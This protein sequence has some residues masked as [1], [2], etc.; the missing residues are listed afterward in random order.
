MGS[1]CKRYKVKCLD[2]STVWV[3]ARWRLKPMLITG[4]PGKAA[5]I[6]SSL[7]GMVRCI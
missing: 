2:E 6:T 3:Q 4:R 1:S 7:P 5:P